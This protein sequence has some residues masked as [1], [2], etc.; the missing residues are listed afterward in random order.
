MS[1]PSRA[2]LKFNDL[3][4]GNDLKN[5]PSFA[6]QVWVDGIPPHVDII[7]PTGTG[8]RWRYRLVHPNT[9]EADGTEL[10][11]PCPQYIFEEEL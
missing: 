9:H 11:Y 3:P 10:E 6:V 5:P 1:K 8:K 7:A 2:T 4:Q